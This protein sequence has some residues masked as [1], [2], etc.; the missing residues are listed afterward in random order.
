MLSLAWG[1]NRQY[2][3]CA[4]QSTVTQYGLCLFVNSH[5]TGLKEPDS[6][7]VPFKLPHQRLIAFLLDF[8]MKAANLA[9]CFCLDLCLMGLT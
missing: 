2:G 4:P 5:L 8:N 1:S 7:G 9:V 3:I 6:F